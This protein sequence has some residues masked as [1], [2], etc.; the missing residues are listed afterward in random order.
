[1]R[2]LT[3]NLIIVGMMSAALLGT[4]C[5]K[6]EIAGEIAQGLDENAAKEL[7]FS[8]L[9]AVDNQFVFSITAD[10]ALALGISQKV[11]NDGLNN[12]EATNAT[13]REDIANG[14]EVMLCA[15][16]PETKFNPNLYNVLWTG[17]ISSQYTYDGGSFY[18]NNNLVYVKAFGATY[19]SST[20]WTC[21]VSMSG[22]TLN[23]YSYGTGESVMQ[24]AVNP[25]APSYNGKYFWSI[26]IS[27][28]S[29]NSGLQSITVGVAESI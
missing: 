29:G 14:I 23:L 15:P 8:N 24:M 16:V 27:T 5:S 21:L 10:E 2:K 25:G 13:I 19:S 1:M 11:Y 9:T 22:A 3:T 12:I 7:L 20:Y 26:N 28:S 4:S 6:T 17:T 18:S